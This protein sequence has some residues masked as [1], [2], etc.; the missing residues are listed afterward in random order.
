LPGQTVLGC[1]FVGGNPQCD[2]NGVC[3][4]E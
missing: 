2:A 3:F 1:P 4:E